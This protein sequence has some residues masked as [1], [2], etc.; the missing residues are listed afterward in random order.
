MN[1]HITLMA[2]I[3]T[4]LVIPLTLSYIFIS[5]IKSLENKECKCSDDIRRKYIKFYGYSLLL[6][7]LL[8]LFIIILAITF[9]KLFIIHQI[10]KYLSVFVNILGIYIIYSYSDILSSS[11][12]DCSKSWKRVFL[13][14]YSYIM[15]T[16]IGLSFLTLVTVF[17]LHIIT[18]NENSIISIKNGFKNC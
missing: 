16:L 18:G 11:E 5:Y 1:K 9:P 12:C 3:S 2:S 10:V 17:I 7:A 13:K 14:Y 15:I 6:F 8:G 4:V